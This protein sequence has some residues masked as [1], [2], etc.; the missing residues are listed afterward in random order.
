[1]YA[2]LRDL[3][4][5]VREGRIAPA[6][7]DLLEQAAQRIERTMADLGEGEVHWGLVHADLC[8]DNYVICGDEVRPLDFD[9]C[10][11]SYYML[12]VAYALLWYGPRNRRAFLEGYGRLWTLPEDHRRLIEAFLVWGVIAMLKFWA[13]APGLVAG[14]CVRYVRGEPFLFD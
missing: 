2:W 4:P 3:Q 12:D 7:Y 8:P 1:M 14:T 13:P 10:G 5:L 9:L 11:F 6:E